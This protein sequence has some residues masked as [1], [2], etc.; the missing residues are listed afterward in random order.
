[1]S[2]AQASPAVV[3][4]ASNL[5][6]VHAFARG[7]PDRTKHREVEALQEQ[8]RRMD[9][10]AKGPV[11]ELSG[12]HFHVARH[13]GRTAPF[14][15]ESE[16]ATVLFNPAAAG[17]FPNV[18]VE[19]RAAFLW[20]HGAARALTEADRIASALL[21][22][23]TP[24]E[25]Q[26]HIGRCDLATDFQG[27]TP[28]AAEGEAYVTKSHDR[29]AFWGRLPAAQKRLGR[30]KERRQGER[31]FTGFMFGRGDVA[32]RLYDKT[33][34]IERSSKQWMRTIWQDAPG[35]KPSAPVWRLEFQLRRPGLA[36]MGLA[37]ELPL[38]TASDVLGCVNGLWRYLAGTWLTL[39][40]PRTKETRQTIRP[41]WD[42]IM[43]GGFSDGPWKGT[44]A[45]IYR[46]HREDLATR[47][48]GQI[49]GYLARGYAEHL[50]H[51]GTM[52]STPTLEKA[53]P[54][55]IGRARDH[56][57]RHGKPVELR[58]QERFT[59]WMLNA[60]SMS[61]DDSM[62]LGEERSHER[63]LEEPDDYRAR[64]RSL[65]KRATREP[66]EDDGE[67]AA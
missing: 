57:K 47:A 4:L 64:V 46:I 67:E 53:L 51:G 62:R 22:R 25:R 13:G 26:L 32:A 37:S 33:T 31:H 2:R 39:R 28:T 11:V 17:T 23:L 65:V 24:E 63:E 12:H 61:M 56:A 52:H 44:E 38:D 8:A 50:F 40:A 10:H 29:A 58:G 5:D 34:E 55:I 19:L 7:M 1:V 21:V 60:E 59:E 14:L 35:Y 45:D 54:V 43:R 9:K 30:G 36:S 18:T 15:L 48:D 3:V 66:G 20:Q 49:A 41:E 6:T 27:W 16:H 42:A